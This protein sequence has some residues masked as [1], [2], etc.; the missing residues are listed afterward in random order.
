MKFRFIADHQETFKVGRMCI[1]LNV[2]RSG[3]YSWL[4]RPESRRSRENRAL[5]DKIRAYHAASH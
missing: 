4:Q 2:S 3:Y 5:E 1:L